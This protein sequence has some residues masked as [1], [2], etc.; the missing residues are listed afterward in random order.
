MRNLSPILAIALLV[1]CGKPDEDGD[2]FGSDIDCNDNNAN[3]FPGATEIC[4]GAD[5]DCDGDIDEFVVPTWYLDFDRDGFGG[6]SF[7]YESCDPLDGYVATFSDCDDTDADIHPDA[8]EVCDEIDNDC[9][10]DSK[11]Q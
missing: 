7:T 2:G 1:A 4:D 3:I 9:D 6:T 10:D 11:A 8:E 5:N